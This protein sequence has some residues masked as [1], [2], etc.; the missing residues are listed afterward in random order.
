[1]AKCMSS[2]P[3]RPHRA[4]RCGLEGSEG[5]QLARPA[6]S[7]PIFTSLCLSTP[8]SICCTADCQL[9]AGLHSKYASGCNMRQI[10]TLGTRLRKL[11]YDVVRAVTF[12]SHPIC[13]SYISRSSRTMA[14]DGEVP[15]VLVTWYLLYLLSLLLHGAELFL[16][17]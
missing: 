13:R 9:P 11:H 6:H 14:G 7:S 17:S 8:R 12:S 16:R 5:P 4:V 10:R 15:A 2:S 1:V 3:A